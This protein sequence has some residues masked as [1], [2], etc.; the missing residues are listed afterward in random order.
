LQQQ[1]HLAQHA[2]AH[3]L[4]AV[5]ES[6]MRNL[7]QPGEERVRSYAPKRELKQAPSWFPAAP[8]ASLQT[9][10]A[11][12]KYGPDTLFFIFYY[13]QNSYQQY[14]AAQE[15]KKQAWRYHKKYLTWFQRHEE[16]KELTPEYET[17]CYLYFDYETGWCQRKKADFT[18]E[19][20][21][22]EE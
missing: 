5:L 13:Q 15:L 3:S 11:I 8:L 6:S 21:F 17:G 12:E 1:Q 10:G 20:R 7:Q 18:F 22:L 4:A 9:P 2:Q 19:Y 16:P 14:L